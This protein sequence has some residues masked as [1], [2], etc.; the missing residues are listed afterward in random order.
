[1]DK[2][3]WPRTTGPVSS[4]P[5]SSGPLCSSARSMPSTASR[6]RPRLAPFIRYA[7]AI[8]HIFLQCAYVCAPRRGELVIRV[9]AEQIQ[10]ALKL[11]FVIPLGADPLPPAAPHLSHLIRMI[12]KPLDG[13]G[14][15]RGIG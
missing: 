4:T 15:A 10:H 12:T 2:R 13:R 6:D 8:P 14:N 1:M 9:P 3:R 7:P 5:W 11:A